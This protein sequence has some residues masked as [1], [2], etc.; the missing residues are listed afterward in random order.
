[1]L[2][3]RKRKVSIIGAGFVGATTAYALMNSGIAT[4][5]CIYDINM[6]NIKVTINKDFKFKTL[7]ADDGYIITNTANGFNVDNYIGTKT[8][9]MPLNKNIDNLIAIT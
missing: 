3:E 6:D 9:I 4:E 5:I 1:M 8:I 7:T 2:Y